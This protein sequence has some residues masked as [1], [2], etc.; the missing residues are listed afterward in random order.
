MC[1]DPST[2][3]AVH[4]PI[5]LGAGAKTRLE[6]RIKKFTRHC[7]CRPWMRM[8]CGGMG[9]AGRRLWQHTPVTT[10]P[11]NIRWCLIQIASNIRNVV[12]LMNFAVEWG[13]QAGNSGSTPGGVTA[14]GVEPPN[15]PHWPRHHRPPRLRL[16]RLPVPQLWPP[17]R[18]RLWPI[19][20]NHV[21]VGS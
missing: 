13:A 15:R 4:A 20:N 16:R 11:I 17:I 1:F 7:V 3:G 12:K 18:P 6:S 8:R 9:S 2:L 14:G 21:T 5:T 10:F 19:M